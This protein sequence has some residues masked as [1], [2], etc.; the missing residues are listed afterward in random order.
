MVI[1]KPVL[2]RIQH[3]KGKNSNYIIHVRGIDLPGVVS[4]CVGIKVPAEV[5]ATF[6]LTATQSPI[7]K[8]TCVMVVEVWTGRRRRLR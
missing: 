7:V 4:A 3:I 2:H 1:F 6:W 5:W 8:Y